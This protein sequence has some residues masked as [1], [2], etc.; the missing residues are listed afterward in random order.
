MWAKLPK[1]KLTNPPTG[2][3]PPPSGVEKPLSKG[4]GG[5]GWTP[6]PTYAA[7]QR[8]RMKEGGDLSSCTSL[9]C[10]LDSGFKTP[11]QACNTA[12][13]SAFGHLNPI[14]QHPLPSLSSSGGL[15]WPQ[16]AAT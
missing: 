1:T 11:E 7:H 6:T 2:H 9:M 3:R 10:L 5:G 15:D 12:L 14:F 4:L 8:T 16:L 13:F